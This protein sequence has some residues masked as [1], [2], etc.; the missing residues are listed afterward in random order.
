MKYVIGII[1]TAAVLFGGVASAQ[2][3]DIT[4]N[5]ECCTF[6]DG[7]FEQT[8]GEIPNFVNPPD[9]TFHN[10]TSDKAGPDG[11]ALFESDT[12]G[13]DTTVPVIGAQ[14]L[15]VGTYHFT[16]TLHGSGMSGDL[17]VTGGTPVARPKISVAI[18]S[19]KLKTVRK[20]GKIKVK[21][22]GLSKASG[23]RLA[24]NKGKQVLG[25]ASKISVST[26]ATRTVSVKLTRS[27]KKAIRDGKKVALV[28][29][30]SVAFGKSTTAKRT[31]R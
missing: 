15:G 29:R 22:K 2:A 26:G 6:V 8:A 10:V 25:A 19:Q 28:A 31:L 24:V 11:E 3:L 23:V 4:S 13:A 12:V 27:G 5:V 18:P 17:V 7:P 21:V 30:G 1:T 20:T 16:C 9:S 14:Y